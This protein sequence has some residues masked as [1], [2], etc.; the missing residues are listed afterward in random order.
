MQAIGEEAMDEAGEM[1]V[2]YTTFPTESDARKIGGELVGRKL[3]ACVNIFPG[4][5][6]IYRWQDAIETGNETAMLVKSR[7]DLRELVLETLRDL[8]PYS[9]PA[10]I[11]FE[12]SQVAA[13][14]L[15]WLCN[16]TAA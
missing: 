14:Y 16:Q 3:A 10:L 1:I 7:K 4:M 9:V 12:P 13:A 2:V 15:A 5:V 6:S 11:V 8:H